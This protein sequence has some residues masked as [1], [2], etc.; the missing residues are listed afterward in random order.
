VGG[1]TRQ[2]AGQARSTLICDTAQA[3]DELKGKFVYATKVKYS[4]SC[5]NALV[6]EVD[7]AL[8]R[9]PHP[10]CRERRSTPN[11]LVPVLESLAPATV[12]P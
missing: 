10:A 7:H 9:T 5:S 4:F 3:Q 2:W 11:L 8:P 6:T 12:F 1:V